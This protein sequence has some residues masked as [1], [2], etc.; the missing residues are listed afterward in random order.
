MVFYQ[1]LLCDA[2][3]LS[4]RYTASN[5]TR[6]KDFKMRP[7]VLFCLSLC[8]WLSR[9]SNSLCEYQ[10]V[11]WCCDDIPPAV[12]LQSQG[13]FG[14]MKFSSQSQGFFGHMKLSLECLS[15]PFISKL[16]RCLFHAYAACAST[17]TKRC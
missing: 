17:L 7:E 13:F 9:V 3:K 8:F 10:L 14:H 5:R 2:C 11:R 15:T 6:Y 4:R 12:S 16:E 1:A